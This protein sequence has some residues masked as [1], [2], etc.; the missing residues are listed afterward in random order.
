MTRHEAEAGLPAREDGWWD[1]FVALEDDPREDGEVPV[2][3]RDT[4]VRYL[5]NRRLTLQLKCAGLDT[6]QMAM[7]A[8]PPSNL[9]LL[10]L[11]RH[12]AGLHPR[13][14]R[15]PGRPVAPRVRCGPA[16]A[17]ARCTGWRQTS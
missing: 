14:D 6:R 7:R 16:P 17:T 8:V 13:A 12:L 2:G 5:R 10:G 1:V 9:S 15:R 11:V 3:E 4:L